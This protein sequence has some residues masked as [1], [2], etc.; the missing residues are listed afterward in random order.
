MS[1]C[2]ASCCTC[3][4]KASSA[5]ATSASSPTA[6]APLSCRFAFNY[7]TPSSHR[8]QNQKPRLPRNR[9]LFGAVLNVAAPWWSSKDLLQPSS[10]FV[11]RPGSPESRHETPIPI[12]LPVSPNTYRPRALSLPIHQAPGFELSLANYN[13]T[14]PACAPVSSITDSPSLSHHGNTIEFA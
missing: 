5:S 6:A 7:S 4:P 1:S 3:S 9:A 14:N 11:L 13:P 8:R 10:N 2:A 12:S